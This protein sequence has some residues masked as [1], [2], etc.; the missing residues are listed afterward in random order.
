[1]FNFFNKKKDPIK[2]WFTTDIHCHIVPGV[3]DGSPDIDTSVNLAGELENLGIKRIIVTPH[4]TQATFEN[5]AESLAGPLAELR[6]GLAD[7]NIGIDIRNSA[8][9]RID[10]FFEQQIA[11]GQLM[12]YPD[13][14]LLIENSFIQEP[15]NMEQ[16]IFDLQVKGYKLILAHPERY[17]YYHAK[18]SRYSELKQL[19]ID[20]QVNLLS[21]AGYYGKG[22][23]RMAEN[24]VEAGMADFIGTD[25]HGRR[26]IRCFEEYLS[27]RDAARHARLLDGKIKN[28]VFD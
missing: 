25:T 26:H 5:S 1:M 19:G 14:Y 20:F 17:L 18:P 27:S 10:E 4:V 23:K 8:E 21:L 13:N 2:L 24:L 6:K 9:Y 12:P 15:W 11:E 22:E 16:I 3:D 7:N 28:H